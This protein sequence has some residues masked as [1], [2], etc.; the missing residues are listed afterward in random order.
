MGG[1]AK[2]LA[3]CKRAGGAWTSTASRVQGLDPRNSFLETCL[4]P[5][6]KGKCDVFDVQYRY[7]MGSR[8][9]NSLD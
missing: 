6:F 2:P 9:R 7:E 3:P 5:V 4:A 1:W 8:P